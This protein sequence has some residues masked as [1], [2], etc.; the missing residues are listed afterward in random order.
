[1][2]ISKK[3]II[4]QGFRGGP[5]FWGGGGGGPNSYFYRN[6]YNMISGAWGGGGGQDPLSLWLGT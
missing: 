2:V 5:T 6:L 3:T 1:M 4:F